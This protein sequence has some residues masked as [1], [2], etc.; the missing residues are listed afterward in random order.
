MPSR[1]VLRSLCPKHQA[2]RSEHQ[3]NQQAAL[4]SAQIFKNIV[5]DD[6]KRIGNSG[7]LLQLSKVVIA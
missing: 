3:G 1:L 4:G 2:Q 7:V 6:Y 5:N